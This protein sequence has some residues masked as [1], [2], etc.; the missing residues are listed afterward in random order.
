L[1]ILALILFGLHLYVRVLPPTTTPIPGPG[2]A[3]SAWWGLW[4]AVY[5]PGW[6][7]FLGGALFFLSWLWSWRQLTRLTEAQT[8]TE[9]AASR[10]WLLPGIAVA[11]F[12]A[13]FMFPIVHTRWGDAYILANGIAWPDPSVRLVYSWQAPLDVFLHSRI[14]LW[15]HELL[16]WND[17]IPVYRI[18]SPIAG[19]FYLLALL[20]LSRHSEL[21]PG[22]L[23]FGFLA[24]LGVLE[25]FFGYIENYSFAAAGI[26]I[27]LWLGLDVLKGRRSLWLA[28]LAL[29]LTNA[30][31]PSTVV[32]A[33]S[34]LYLGWR[35]SLRRG[36][37][38][39]SSGNE[40]S[41]AEAP[42]ATARHWIGTAAAIAIPM[43]VVATATILFMERGGHGLHSLV[44]SD[45]PGGG[46]GRWLVP[47]FQ[48]ATKW[49]HYTMFSWPHLRDF[50]NEQMLVA[51]VV[52]PAL[53]ICT[54]FLLFRRSREHQ[55]RDDRHKGID[56]LGDPVT[57][58]LLLAAGFHLLLTWLWNPDYG[59][60]RDWDL[61]SLAAIPVTLLFV[62]LFS[63][64]FRHRVALTAAAVPLLVLQALHLA[65]WVY[66]NTLPWHWP[67]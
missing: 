12:L 67:G 63:R 66:Q 6:A 26:L 43:L 18:L 60:Q 27:Y 47:L 45:R 9:K 37:H 16:N 36:E 38:T 50:L 62:H 59:G 39:G 1:N 28:A 13:F 24:T 35:S 34:L 53:L 22:W 19:G 48:T 32:L 8:T 41:S 33:P 7:I 21:A 14:W 4:P 65:A 2:D 46:D 23:T 30:F 42:V 61:F 64:V 57:G 25:L 56:R 54:G 49:E 5:V 29:A 55:Q 15:L 58:Y 20:G 11:L 52:L 44:S 3:E 31:H 51:P 40:T 10:P 17:A